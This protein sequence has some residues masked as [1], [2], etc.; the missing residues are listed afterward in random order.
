[1]STAQPIDV[2]DMAIVYHTFRRAYGEIASSPPV[3]TAITGI[4]EGR[5]HALS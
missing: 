5:N 1:M 3:P 4:R 2:R